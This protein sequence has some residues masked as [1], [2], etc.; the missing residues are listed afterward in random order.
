MEWK[1]SRVS[2][3]LS[4]FRLRVIRDSLSDTYGSQILLVSGILNYGKI[5]DHFMLILTQCVSNSLFT[6]A[7]DL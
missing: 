4:S 6:P 2:N 1:A 7:N 3:S 5:R